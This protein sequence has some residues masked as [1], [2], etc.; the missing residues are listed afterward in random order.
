MGEFGLFS[1]TWWQHWIESGLFFAFISIGLAIASG[2]LGV[3]Q[4]RK[5]SEIKL[6]KQKA[7]NVKNELEE[8][9]EHLKRINL[10]ESNH[11]NPESDRELINKACKSVQLLGIN[12]LGILHHTQETLVDFLYK[13]NGIVQI[14]LLNPS[15]EIFKNRVAFEDD[16]VGRLYSEW[17]AAIRILKAIDRR[18]EGKGELALKLRDVTPDRSLAIFDGI[19]EPNEASCMLINYYPEELGKR[20]YTGGQYLAEYSLER[21]V[22]SYRTN[23]EEFQRLWKSA[24]TYDLEAALKLISETR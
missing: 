2:I 15:T 21:D 4:Y 11:V 10:R 17:D 9:I 8:K 20:G 14:L 23:E 5:N 22:D 13:K 19:D 3:L 24:E 7:E 12:S 18:R 1:E 6:I 16:C